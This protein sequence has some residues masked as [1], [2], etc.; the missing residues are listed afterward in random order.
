MQTT[1]LSFTVFLLLRCYLSLG[2][3]LH[4]GRNR[5]EAVEYIGE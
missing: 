1:R 5:N 4:L 2:S 3:H